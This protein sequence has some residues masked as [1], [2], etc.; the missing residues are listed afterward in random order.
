MSLFCSTFLR[1]KQGQQFRCIDVQHKAERLIAFAIISRYDKT[2]FSNCKGC[3]LI[4]HVTCE[5][6]E[7]SKAEQAG[8]DA[9]L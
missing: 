3:D 2:R 7:R 8:R 5:L 6:A 9:G 4:G 1:L